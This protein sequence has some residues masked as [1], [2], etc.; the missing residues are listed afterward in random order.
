[1]R[2]NDVLKI[3]SIDIDSET[4]EATTPIRN[5]FGKLENKVVKKIKGEDTIRLNFA[6]DF[7]YEFYRKILRAYLLSLYKIFFI[8]VQKKCKNVRQ[9]VFMRICNDFLCKTNCKRNWI[10]TWQIWL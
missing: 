4:W 7:H 8:H 6:N 2:L 1:M 10:C 3:E 5:E 9:L